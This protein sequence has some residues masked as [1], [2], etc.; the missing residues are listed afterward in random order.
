MKQDDVA[1]HRQ[2]AL[3]DGVEDQ[4]P[5]PRQEE[6]IFDDD[7]AGQ[8]LPELEA[9]DGQDRDQRVAQG[10]DIDDGPLP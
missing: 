9:H 4:P 10:M 1:H 7:R 8:Q 5:Q 6:D 2:V 3:A